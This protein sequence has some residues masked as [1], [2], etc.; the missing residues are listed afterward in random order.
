LSPLRLRATIEALRGREFRR[1]TVAAFALLVAMLVVAGAGAGSRPGPT[2]SV[3]VASG[4]FG[5]SDPVLVELTFSNPTKHPVHLLSWVTGAGALA[6]P[7]FK[8][9]RDG[10]PVSYTG[11]IVKRPRAGAGDYVALKSGEQLTQV[12]D[13]GDAYDLT[14]SGSYEIAYD[15]S[16]A[17][18]FEGNG[19]AAAPDSLTSAPVTAAVKGRADKG[20]P[21]GGGG[22][23]TGTFTACSLTQQSQLTAARTNASTYAQGALGY[24]N[25]G[26]AGP[27]Y[28]TWFG[29]NDA[30]RY[31]RVKSNFGAIA[32][33][34]STQNITFDSAASRTC[35]PTSIPTSRTRSTSAGSTGRRPRWAP[36]PRQGRS[37]TR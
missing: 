18:L 30:G 32:S 13:L 34:F 11:P 5:T 23:G 28:T 14:Q 25:G 20:K 2:V 35:T 1:R 24:L 9:T 6:A 19:S 22:G 26:A 16:S 3:S 27:R 8:V 36:I 4:S 10:S 12:V 7:I 31:A 21:G 17:E 37:S 33:A 15:V 29:A